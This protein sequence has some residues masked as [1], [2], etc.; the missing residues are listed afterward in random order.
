[1]PC[2]SDYLKASGGEQESQRVC[3]CLVY[4]YNRLKRDVPA[5]IKKASKSYYGNVD[6]LD[7][8]TKLLCECLRGLNSKETEKFVYDGHHKKARRLAAWWERHQEWDRRRVK[9][10]EDARNKVILKGRA[11]KKLTVEEIDALDLDEDYDDD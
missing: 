5:W 3:K 9:E 11:L 6:R 7:E 1:M 8:A 10:E 2:Q 4:L